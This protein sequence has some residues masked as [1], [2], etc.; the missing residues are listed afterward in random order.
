MRRGIQNCLNWMKIPLHPEVREC[1]SPGWISWRESFNHSNRK[2]MGL[3]RSVRALSAKQG[4]SF[5][6][7]VDDL[8]P[9]FAAYLN[10]LKR[11][12]SAKKNKP[13]KQQQHLEADLNDNYR[14]VNEGSDDNDNVSKSSILH[15]LQSRI[16]RT[17]DSMNSDF[18]QLQT[19][20]PHPGL[21]TH[22]IVSCYGTTMPIQDL[23]TVSVSQN[24]IISVNVYDSDIRKNVESA[25]IKAN[26]GLHPISLGDS[27]EKLSSVIH[28]PVPIL[29]N[30][31]KKQIKR[32]INKIG[33]S[34]KVA[35]RNHRKE[36]MQAI[37]KLQSLTEDEKRRAEKEVQKLVDESLLITSKATAGKESEI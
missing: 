3:K 32:V 18:K 9:S 15:Q 28:V 25:I 37:R 30:E 26:L 2:V 29:D 14:G 33:E 20:V 16:D 4:K 35:I 7:Y 27:D 8:H 24:R 17:F 31:G 1:S 13:K 34:S 23:A 36:A 19:G 12:F 6:S 5:V 11:N 21:I 22:I 10:A